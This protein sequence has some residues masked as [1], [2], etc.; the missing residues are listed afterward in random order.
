[1]NIV[2]FSH[3]TFL[4]SLSMIRYAKWLAEGME[5]RGHDVQIWIPQA[6]CYN[7]PV[8]KNLKKWLGYIDQY[9]IF[10]IWVKNQIKKQP[11]KTLYVLT[12]HALGLWA[13]LIKNNLHVVHCHD[14][15]AQYS[16]MN[17]IPEN[18]V[19][20]SGRKYQSYIKKGF[21]K[22][23]NFISISEKTRQDLHQLLDTDPV[24]SEVVYNGL[25]RL[26]IPSEN[27]KSTLSQLKKLTN[28]D[29]SAGYILHVGGN[30]WNKN[31]KGVIEIYNKWRETFN[32]KLPLLMIGPFPNEP[33][34]QAFALSAFNENIHFLTDKTDDF[35]CLAYQGASAFIFPSLAEG[36]GWPIAESMASG[37]PVV[38]TN[39]APMTEVAGN[40]ALF[41][42]CRPS[43][44]EKVVAWATASAHVI[45]TV[46]SYDRD[47]RK[48]LTEKGLKNVKR[49]DNE[50]TIEKIEMIYASIL[51]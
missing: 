39:E 5:K 2:F 23:R 42:E 34:I 51:G 31:R 14:F 36:F 24:V 20:W 47:I 8:S 44:E 43:K 6:K 28:I 41:I 22:S 7:L 46:L 16:A 17:R 45:E 19:G 3:P 29:L 9:V 12:D 18:P 26:Y 15:L 30:Q 37:T 33:L 21:S 40:A 32:K 35:V 13:P 1:M 38:T 49:F 10:P 11:K 27:L 50:K 48:Q 4:G 25:T